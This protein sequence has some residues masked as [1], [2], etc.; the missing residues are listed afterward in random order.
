MLLKNK[1]ALA[2]IIGVLFIASCSNEMAIDS[3]SFL[4]KDNAWKIYTKLF[5]VES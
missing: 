5:H 4:K 3:F 1:L 2:S